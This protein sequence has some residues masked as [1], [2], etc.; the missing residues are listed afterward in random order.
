M[1]HFSNYA[2]KKF[3]LLN[4]HKVF[5]TK[6]QVEETIQLADKIYKKDKYIFYKKAGI[7]VV[8]K[9]INNTSTIVTFF[10]STPPARRFGGRGKL[11]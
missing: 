3:D 1:L 5:V 2:N 4:K 9:K 7:C 10:P 6:E 8:I 11:P